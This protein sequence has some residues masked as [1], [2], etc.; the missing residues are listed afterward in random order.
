MGHHRGP[1]AG[2]HE[3]RGCLQAAVAVLVLTDALPMEAVDLRELGMDERF[4]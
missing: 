3:Q 2:S 4:A 1:L